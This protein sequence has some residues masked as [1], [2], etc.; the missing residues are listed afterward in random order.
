[1]AYLPSLCTQACIATLHTAVANA[2]RD[3]LHQLST[4]LVRAHGTV[5]IENPRIARAAGTATGRP[6]PRPGQRRHRKVTTA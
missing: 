1:M 4:R 2:R 5:M 6:G 3:G